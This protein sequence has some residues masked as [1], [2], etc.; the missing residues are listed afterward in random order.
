MEIL[1]RSFNSNILILNFFTL[2]VW[3]ACTRQRFPSAFQEFLDASLED[4]V[5][6]RRLFSQLGK[7]LTLEVQQRKDQQGLVEKEHQLTQLA[8]EGSAGTHRT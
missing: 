5:N 8:A 3:S 2:L 6:I 1:G 7:R 4:G